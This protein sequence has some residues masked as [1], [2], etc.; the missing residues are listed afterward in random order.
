VSL[1]DTPRIWMCLR[2]M[3]DIQTCCEPSVSLLLPKPAVCHV[4]LLQTRGQRH[5][6]NRPSIFDMFEIFHHSNF[7]PTRDRGPKAESSIRSSCRQK[8]SFDTQLCVATSPLDLSW[9]SRDL[10]LGA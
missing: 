1:H 3:P 5:E 8:Y 4:L 7:R 2:G 10:Q 9:L 6:S